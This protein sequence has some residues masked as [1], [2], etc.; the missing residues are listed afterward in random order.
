[1][2]TA[3]PNTAEGVWSGSA[4]IM[5]YTMLHSPGMTPRSWRRQLFS[6]VMHGLKFLNLFNLLD[7]DTAPGPDYVG[8]TAGGASHYV[9]ARRALNE[10]GNFDDIVMHGA[11]QSAGSPVALLMSE[12]GD[13]FHDCWGTAGAAKRSLYIALKHRQ[14]AVDVVI[15]EDI[16]AAPVLAQYTVIYIVDP[17]VRASAAHALLA[18]VSSGGGTLVSTVN[19]ALLDESNASSALVSVF[20]AGFQPT[21]PRRA[22][23]VN[24]IKRDLRFVHVLGNATVDWGSFPPAWRGVVDPDAAAMDMPM[25]VLGEQSH[26]SWREPT[27]VVAT[28]GDGSAAAVVRTYPKGGVAFYVGWHAV[29]KTSFVLLSC[30]SAAP[31]RQ[32]QHRC[33]F[34]SLCAN[35]IS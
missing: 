30:N 26:M 15:E 23:V 14:L 8:L 2:A 19:G 29:R 18:W 6:D 20:G 21:M 5:M 12:T 31:G 16:E 17:H 27:Q 34:Q 25:A 33:K 7:E 32:R 35:G 9:E 10:V 11:A 28:Y 4:P 13:I 22:G 1:M 24:F 3:N